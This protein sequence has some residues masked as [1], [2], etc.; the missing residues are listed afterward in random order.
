MVSPEIALALALALTIKE[1]RRGQGGE[2]MGR[3]VGRENNI[4]F[5]FKRLEKPYNEKYMYNLPLCVRLITKGK[6]S[7]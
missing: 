2:H 1:K 6:G 3:V 4:I 7:W 5:N